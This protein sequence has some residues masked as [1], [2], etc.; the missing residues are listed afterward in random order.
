MRINAFSDVCLRLLML[1]A[2]RPDTLLKT[3]DIAEAIDIPYNQVS[4]AVHRLGQ[5]GHLDVRRGRTGGVQINPSGLSLG[6]GTLL[7]SL[8]GQ[9]DLA[10]CTTADGADACPL[11]AGC[12]L[13]TALGRAQEAFYQELDRWPIRDLAASPA[14]RTLPFPTFP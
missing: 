3:R 9:G 8:E 5:L 12:R 13:R 2:S 1:L 10:E 11:I 7:R 4:K 14:L 6:A